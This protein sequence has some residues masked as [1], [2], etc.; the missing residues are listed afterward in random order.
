MKNLSLAIVV[1]LCTISSF[2]KDSTLPIID[3]SS[4][5]NPLTNTG[6]TLFTEASG[7]D[8][9]FIAH[10]D[11][12]S[13]TNVSQ[14]PIVAMV[15]TMQIRDDDRVVIERLE[16]FDAFFYPTLLN[17][18]QTISPFSQDFFATHPVDS[19]YVPLSSPRCEVTTRWVQFSDGTSFG[20]PSY[21]RSL[22]QSRIALLNNLEEL[23]AVYSR[24]G[25]D[26]F[27]E[28]LLKPVKPATSDAYVNHLRNVQKKY[29]SNKALES[30]NTHLAVGEQRVGLNASLPS[31]GVA[32]QRSTD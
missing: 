22:G 13:V 15:V 25:L 14:K 12:W 21:A 17:P 4:A 16:E 30:L 29:G 11:D 6:S 23:K 19:K 26:K 18:G 3:K 31:N 24:E 7:M 9:A 10:K 20:D 5:G 27:A 1:L 2:A 28:Q 8:G 32:P